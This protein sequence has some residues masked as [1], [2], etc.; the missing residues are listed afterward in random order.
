MEMVSRH[1]YERVIEEMYLQK[2][3]KWLSI[4]LIAV[5]LV[6]GCVPS[7]FASVSAKVNTSSAKAYKKAYTG[8]TSVDV[9]KGLKLSVTD[10]SGS[11]AKVSYKGVTAY[12]PV[13]YL[14]PTNKLKAYTTDSTTAYTTSGARKGTLAKGTMLYVLG[15][16]DGYYCVSSESGSIG[17]V[18]KG[19]L[20]ETKPSTVAK[21]EEVSDV[22]QTVAT[23]TSSGSKIDVAIAIGKSL[24]GRPYK[25][26]S[27]PPSSFDCSSFV[28]YCLS[29]AGFSVRG[30]SATQA[31]DSRYQLIT[32]V[33][34][35]KKGD[36]LCFDTSE[37]GNVDHSA[38]Y[39]GD[40]KF[41]E[42]SSNAGIVHTNS[43]SSWYKKHFVCA[44]RP[45]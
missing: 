31:A 42:A 30:T 2:M 6:A 36:I 12:M 23:P 39:M 14:T 18:K 20:S 1:I 8:A 16:L 45:A 40:G 26:G 37:D 10:I 28:K 7:A 32:S 35:L 24:I 34:D 43:M 33:S 22:K 13:K 11:W 29:K 19:T 27:N 38:L 9:A 21:S 25:S 41:I 3:R 17:L 15:T 44:R 5:I 4:L